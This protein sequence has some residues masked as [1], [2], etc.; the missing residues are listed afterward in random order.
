MHPIVQ[1]CSTKSSLVDC[2]QS[3]SCVSQLFLRLE[4]ALIKPQRIEYNFKQGDVRNFRENIKTII[5]QWHMVFLGFLG[6]LG[7]R[8]GLLGV[9]RTFDNCESYNDFNK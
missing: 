3:S 1:H 6:L 8:W 4:L 5:T 2:A 7:C 9:C